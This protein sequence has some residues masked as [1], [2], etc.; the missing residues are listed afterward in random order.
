MIKI[1]TNHNTY[2]I[3][4]DHVEEVFISSTKIRVTMTSGYVNNLTTDIAKEQFMQQWNSIVAGPEQLSEP[5]PDKEPEQKRS[6][7]DIVAGAKEATKD[8]KDK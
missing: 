2:Y 5:M 1:E 8:D 6:L 7:G 3:N 4:P